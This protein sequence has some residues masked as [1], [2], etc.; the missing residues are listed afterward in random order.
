MLTRLPAALCN[1][2]S[3][4][5]PEGL[6]EGKAETH[7]GLTIPAEDMLANRAARA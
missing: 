1:L 5:V 7:G 4:D 2:E 6:L 3:C